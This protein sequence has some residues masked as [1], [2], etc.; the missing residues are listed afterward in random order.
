LEVSDALD[1]CVYSG[2]QKT[3]SVYATLNGSYLFAW[4]DSRSG[5]TSDIYFQSMTDN[6]FDY[7]DNGVILC[8]ADFNQFNPKIDLYNETNGS[9]MIYW[10][11][12]RSSGKEDLKNIYVQSFTASTSECNIMDVNNDSIINVIDIVQVVNIVLGSIEPDTYQNCA[13]D[14]NGD[15]IIN[16]IDIVNI[17]N[18][19]LS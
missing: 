6:I 1:L 19:I 7:T 8:D 17:V 16:V 11:D 15:G 12:M 2:N 13:A 3:P 18:F 5:V 10:D 9:Y 4:E 14:I